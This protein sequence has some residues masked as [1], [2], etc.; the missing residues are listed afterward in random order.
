MAD[1]DPDAFLGGGTAVAEPPKFD[2]DSFLAKDDAPKFN[3]DEFLAEPSDYDKALS[4]TQAGMDAM[5]GPGS[6]V[7]G[8]FQANKMLDAQKQA[9]SEEADFMAGGTPQ[10]D[11]SQYLQGGAQQDMPLEQMGFQT[12]ERVKRAREAGFKLPSFH[13][14]AQSPS[15]LLPKPDNKGIGTGIIR[16]LETTAESLSS[17][18]NIALIASIGGA[19]RAIQRA[20]LAGFTAM[21]AK[22]VPEQVKAILDAGSA[23]E[24]AEKITETVASLAM[25][26]L[27]AKELAGRPHLGGLVPGEVRP[28][29]LTQEAA[30]TAGRANQLRALTPEGIPLTKDAQRPVNPDTIDGLTIARE[31]LSRDFQEQPKEAQAQRQTAI[32]EIDDQLLR[33]SRED[34]QASAERIAQRGE[35]R[36]PASEAAPEVPAGGPPAEG[37]SSSLFKQAQEEAA[38][39]E[40][41]LIEELPPA[42]KPEG[43][44][45]SFAPEARVKIRDFD[46][47]G[48]IGKEVEMHPEEAGRKLRARES[49]FKSLLDCLG[50]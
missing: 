36:P 19:P 2:P 1:F 31:R 30:D 35:S 18:E 39:K 3:P 45:P 41:Q 16:G 43:V 10:E 27:G 26:G 47:K 42:A 20:A 13:E 12:R 50:R 23:G 34:A 44:E 8:T 38:P 28:P 46:E 4:A 33:F 24:K 40:A 17:P 32:D 48:R 11:L 5:L 14:S 37:G 21:M 49:A 29:S 6:I 9:S 25:L 22:D 7:G 15:I